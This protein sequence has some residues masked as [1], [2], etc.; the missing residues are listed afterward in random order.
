MIHAIN[1]YQAQSLKKS[2]CT[3]RSHMGSGN[4]D[5]SALEEDDYTGKLSG[6]F[7]LAGNSCW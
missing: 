7:I 2:M 1:V 6:S 5:T 3:A 4:I